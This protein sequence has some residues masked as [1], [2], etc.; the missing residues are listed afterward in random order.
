MEKDQN[1]VIDRLVQAENQLE[2]KEKENIAL[3]QKK[4]YYKLELQ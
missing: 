3:L 4:N 1:E 2:N